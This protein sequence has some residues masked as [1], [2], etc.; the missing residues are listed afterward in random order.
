MRG[1]KISIISLNL[2][3]YFMYPKEFINSVLIAEIGLIK[4][5]H[6]YLA[7]AL[8]CSGIEFLGKCLSKEDWQHY[9]S[10]GYYFKFAIEELM[11]RYKPLKEDLYQDLRN[12][13]AHVLLP[14]SKIAL[15]QISHD[16]NGE[17]TPGNHPYK[18]DGHYILL[19][20]YFYND[21][22]E[23]CKKVIRKK[24][25]H[26]KSDKYFCKLLNIPD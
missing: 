3:E 16:K 15:T 26:V 11:P 14:K 8:I 17:I 24:E 4:T 12:G 2:Y 22:V 7:F 23:A 13:M 5:K 21:F 19:I 20:E 6:P 18:K 9:K 1:I 25:K 10:N